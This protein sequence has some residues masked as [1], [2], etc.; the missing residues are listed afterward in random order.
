MTD[1]GP[2]NGDDDR[3]EAT[4]LNSLDSR[5]HLRNDEGDINH[6]RAA[7]RPQGVYKTW[8]SVKSFWA[9]QVNPVVPHETCRDHFGKFDI[10][11]L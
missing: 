5:T 7:V 6:S 4:H 9:C 10:V 2:V 8:H 1:S 11:F 3:I